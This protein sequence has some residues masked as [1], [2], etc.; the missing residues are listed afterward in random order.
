MEQ[1]VKK[2]VYHHQVYEIVK[3]QILS[4]QLPSGQRINENALAQSLGV[5]RSPVREAMRMLEQDHLLVQRPGGLIVNPLEADT[6]LDIYECR[7][8]LE[9][10]A[11]R[12]GVSRLSDGDIALLEQYVQQSMQAHDRQDFEEV[13]TCN[14]KFHEMLNHCCDNKILLHT[15]DNIHHL[16]LL[17]RTQEFACHKRDSSYLQEHMGVV[18]ALKLRDAELVEARMREHISNDRRFYLQRSGPASSAGQTA[19]AREGA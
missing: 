13:I 17:A 14:T 16:S 18:E 12:C 1:V 7:I 9:S 2:T 5:S 19:Q 11:A 10:Y 8:L 4:G 15:M 6:V 3:R